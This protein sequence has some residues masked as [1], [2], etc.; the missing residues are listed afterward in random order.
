M[1]LITIPDGYTLASIET[2]R[3]GVGALFVSGDGKKF[4]V[5]VSPDD[6]LSGLPGDAQ[7]AI[8]SA[9]TQEMADAHAASLV[10]DP[11][12]VADYSDAIQHHIDTAA[13][14]RGYRDG[15]ALAGYVTSTIQGWAEEAI[16]FIA[17]RDAVWSH[18]YV[19]LAK[20]QGGWRPQPTISELI[21]ELP[22][23]QW[24]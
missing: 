24:P 12:T 19:E 3:M 14:S 8:T 9:I 23:I 1:S 6:D 15:F 5:S 2:R 20:V 11:V 18:A 21:A 7:T 4:R 10:P 16:A 13:R 22:T 17:W